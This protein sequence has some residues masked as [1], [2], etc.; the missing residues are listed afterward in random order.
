MFHSQNIQ[1]KS[2]F[3]KTKFQFLQCQMF[4]NPFDLITNMFMEMTFIL[5]GDVQY[6]EMISDNQGQPRVSKT[7]TNVLL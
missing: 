5:V 2:S 7:H 6:V 4:I 3:S 1:I